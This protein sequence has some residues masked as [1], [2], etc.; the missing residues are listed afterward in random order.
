MLQDLIYIADRLDKS[1]FYAKANSIDSIIKKI[2]EL[3]SEE[4]SLLDEESSDITRTLE[5]PNPRDPTWREYGG[6][7]GETIREKIMN[8]FSDIDWTKLGEDWQGSQPDPLL[9]HRDRAVEAI[10]SGNIA[11]ELREYY[12]FINYL[13]LPHDIVGWSS[14]SE[15][16]KNSIISNVKHLK[17]ILIML[18]N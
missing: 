16:E 1:G 5:E 3:N 15:R 6:G 8:V 7:Y 11:D 18:A 12:Y 10:K 2:A 17:K 9:K 14:M 13:D 4:T